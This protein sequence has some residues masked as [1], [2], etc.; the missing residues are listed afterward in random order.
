MDK[1]Q[2]D[3]I[4]ENGIFFETLGMTRMA[5]RVFGYLIVS[6]KKEAS[7]DD[8]RLAL[9]ASKGSISGTTKQLINIGFLQPVSLPGDRKTY[10]RLN[11]IEVGKILEAR[12]QMFDKFSEMISK[13]DNLRNSEDEQTEWLKEIST[14]YDWVG[15]E[16]REIIKKWEREKE[17]IIDNYENKSKK[18]KS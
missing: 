2:L 9:K 15:D 10:F 6:D 4:E 14:F 13:G 3:Y 18:Q 7:F 11:K 17:K 8:I 12:I 5:G 1:R 16:I